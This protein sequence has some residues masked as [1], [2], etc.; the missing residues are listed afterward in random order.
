MA[1]DE[2]LADRVRDALIDVDGVTERKMFGGLAFM[3]D[4]NM[5]CGPLGEGMIVRVGKDAYEE[6]LALPGASKMEFTGRPMSGF[7]TVSPEAL[8]GDEDLRDWI[9]RGLAFVLTLPP[10]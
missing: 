3:V 6:V 8:A 1:Y 7:V 2:A 9:R 5:L 10:K 4:G